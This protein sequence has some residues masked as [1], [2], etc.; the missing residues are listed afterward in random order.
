MNNLKKIVIERA[1]YDDLLKAYPCLEKYR[2]DFVKPNARSEKYRYYSNNCII[3]EI[4][5]EEF[6]A[7]VKELMKIED[8][9]I[10]KNRDNDYGIDY[11]LTIYDYYLE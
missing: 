3:T 8:V 6:W 9:V 2:D 7:L 11:T 4:T 5:E 1:D 10:S